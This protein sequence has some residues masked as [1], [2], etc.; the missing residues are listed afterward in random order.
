[1]ST[2]STLVPLDGGKG[3]E[4]ENARGAERERARERRAREEE[5][6]ERVCE[7]E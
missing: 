3:R 7:S 2:C 4:R 1:V 6:G 5:L